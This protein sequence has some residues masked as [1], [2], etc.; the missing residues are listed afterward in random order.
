MKS[1]VSVT[2]YGDGGWKVVVVA[3]ILISMQALMITGRYVSR[4]MRKVSLAIDDYTLL[5]AVVLT[6]GLCALA[7]ACK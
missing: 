6:V 1:Y 2:D 5:L 3:G 7:I 4:R